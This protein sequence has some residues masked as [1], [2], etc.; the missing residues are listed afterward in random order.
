MK[1]WPDVSVVTV[2]FNHAD[3]LA[4]YIE[5]VER[6]EVPV[7]EI[8]IVD[9]HSI[10]NSLEILGWYPRVR[11]VRN[12]TNLGYSAA[13]NQ[14]F[15]LAISPLV[16]ATG[17]DVVV[18]PGWLKPLIEQYR[19]DPTRTFAV[20]SR[21]LTLDRTEIQSAGSS[22]HFTG[23]LNV[24]EMWQPASR[25]TVSPSEP[26]EVGA[27]DSTS[28]LVD[29]DKYLAIGGCDP[30]FFVYHEEFDYCYRARLRG[31]TC[32]YEPHS[33]VYHGSGTGEFSVRSQGSYPRR[34]PYLHTRNR[35]LSMFKDYQ[36][37][38]LIGIL[39]ALVLTELLN[40]GLLLKM[41]L[42]GA[43]W[44]AWRWLWVNRRAIIQKRREIQR[45]RRVSDR[46]L[47]TADPLTISPIV[48]SHAPGRLMKRTL[49]AGLKAYWSILKRVLYSL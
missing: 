41:K 26:R 3:Y 15:A 13:L 44:E 48:L 6:S 45:E 16:C 32:W 11:V 31:W 35:W 42:P 29:R 34:R 1:Q 5:S 46:E 47:L 7:A 25:P 19:R 23:H 22:L 21:V 28:M 8:L 40:F 49:D 18:E 9:N 30:D 4:A 27:V 10:D 37:R 17:P 38:T 36:R 2:N 20:G 39:P 24:F 14:C 12:E 33:V 43:Y